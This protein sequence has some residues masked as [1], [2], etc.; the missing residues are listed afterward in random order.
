VRSFQRSTTFDPVPASVVGL[1]RRIDRGAGAEERHLDQL[2]QL[3][4]ALREEARIESV[5]AS[6]AIEGVVVDPHRAPGLLAG[7]T[8]RFKTRS[9]AEFAGYTTALD[10]LYAGD[11]G[12]LAVGLILHLHRLLSPR[13][14]GPGG[15]FKA[16]DNLVVDREPDGT[17]S[18]RF[19]PVPAHETAFYVSELVERTNAE[20][21][22]GAHHPLIVTA[23]CVLDLTCI[24]P[25]ADG[26]G[27]VAR[28]LTTY[29]LERT[30]YGVGR[31]VSVE[32]LLYDAKDDY[33]A[34]LAASTDGW[35]DDGSHSVWS[36]TEFLLTQV[37]EVYRRF[38]ARIAAGR[39]GA[40]KQERVRDYVVLHAPEVFSIADVR[41]AV[42]GVSDH[43][44][45][46]VLTQLRDAG[47]IAPQGSGRA[48]CW[49]RA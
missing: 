46:L 36:W 43:T 10:H 17:R 49:K 14:E 26:N 35:F 23:A 27:R 16:E 47:R 19:A 34:A 24:H 33:Y 48:A 39:A 15:S 32:Q 38:E 45:R 11:A 12:E 28:L 20:L 2:P 29:L 37:A 44:I 9:E 22:V 1:L 3:L 18:V 21:A 8:K 30:G 41:R 5:T 4:L 25:F 7:R 42:P 31:Y 13:T 40:T 6:S